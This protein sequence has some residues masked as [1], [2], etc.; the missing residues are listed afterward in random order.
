M[1]I[2]LKGKS[3]MM[4]SL[5]VFTGSSTETPRPSLRGNGSVTGRTGMAALFG[6]TA[7]TM[8][9]IGK[10]R[11]SMGWASMSLKTLESSERVNGKTTFLLE[12]KFDVVNIYCG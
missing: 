1:A 9:A 4:G 11:S 5:M 12:K 10:M 7:T 3:M 6:M 2:A 8:R